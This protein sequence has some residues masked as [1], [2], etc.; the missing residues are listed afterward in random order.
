MIN[1][2]VL[3]V[4]IVLILTI[5]LSKLLTLLKRTKMKELRLIVIIAGVISLIYTICELFLGINLESLL[6]YLTQ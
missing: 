4:V 1:R 5:V 3:G 6:N 2:I